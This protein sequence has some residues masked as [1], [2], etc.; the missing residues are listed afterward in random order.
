MNELI[1]STLVA[2]MI[3]APMY[4]AYRIRRKEGEKFFYQD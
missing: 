2:A 4:L 3:I 1:F